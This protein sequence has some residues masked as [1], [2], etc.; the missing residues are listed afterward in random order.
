MTQAE[1]H[2]RGAGLDE[3]FLAFVL[4]RLALLSLPGEARRAGEMVVIRTEGHDALIEML[5][6]ACWLG[7]IDCGVDTIDRLDPA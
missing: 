2:V 6:M 4:H 1:L 5:E 7:P 3:A